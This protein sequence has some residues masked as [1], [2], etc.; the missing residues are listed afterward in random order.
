[1]HVEPFMQ[2]L[3][4]NGS[5]ERAVPRY[6]ST[7]HLPKGGHVQ[8]LIN[9]AHSRFGSTMGGDNTRVYPALATVSR[10]LFGICAVD[11]DGSVYACGD[12]DIAF[13]MMSVAKPFV[14]ALLC[15]EFGPQK[16]RRVIGVNATGLPYGSLTAV[17]RSAAG[18][19]N[20]MVNPGAIATTNLAPGRD[21]EAQWEFLCEGISRF[22]G[23]QLALDDAVY[24]SAS[25]TNF[26]NQSAAQLLA[27]YRL[28]KDPIAAVELY[29]RQSCLAVTARDL[30]TMG[31]TL[32]NGGVN[33]LTGVRV[34]E[35]DVCRYTLAVMATAGLYENS[36]EWLYA[37]GLPGKS[38]IG[39]GIVTAAPGKGG[40]GTYAPPLD[41]A[42]N[43]VK[44][45][46]A[47][48]FLSEQ[49]GLNLFASEPSTNS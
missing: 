41:E 4:M 6:V 16:V 43:S 13:A 1:M 44:G 37:I 27:D 17:E 40:L 20:P 26:R 38:G 22:A 21:P 29:T 47:T 3:C 48:R 25:A 12:S 28:V 36:G 30:A 34:V 45:Q 11:V 8:A 35:A 10:E 9:D 31:A 46:K 42:G 2:T 24:R 18:R 39:G 49:L 33:P 5:S 15:Q 19:T 7:G 32:A 23:H 14:F